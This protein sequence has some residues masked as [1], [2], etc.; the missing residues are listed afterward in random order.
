MF[1]FFALPRIVIFIATISITLCSLTQTVAAVTSFF[2]YPRNRARIS[3]TSLELLILGHIIL[4]MILHMQT[5]DEFR[6]GILISPEFITARIFLFSAIVLAVISV[7]LFTGKTRSVSVVIVASMTLP[8]IEHLTGYMFIY[9]NLAVIIIWFV[10]SI[11]SGLSY[12]KENRNSLS[13]SSAKNM[14]DSMITGVMFC[15]QDGFILLVN[16]QMQRLMTKITGKVQRNGRHFFGMLTLGETDPECS[17]AWFEDKNVIILPDETAWQFTITELLIGKKTYIQMTATEI[18]EQWTLTARLNPQ[19]ELLMRRQD[20][21]NET[22]ENLH[23]LSR[24]Q[25]TQR[26]KMRIHDVLGKHL[27]VLQST[28]FNNRTPDYSLLKTM[29]QELLDDLKTPP[30][31]PTPWDE[32]ETME[33]IF[34]AIGVGIEI[35][36]EMPKDTAKGRLFTDIT[37]EAVTNAVRHGLATRVIVHMDASDGNSHL[38]ITDNGHPPLSVKEG[39][40]I[41]GMRKMIEPFGGSLYIST[42]PKF[43]LLVVLPDFYAKEEKQ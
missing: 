3:E 8:V 43:V 6:S 9:F 23:I 18:S 26:A 38:K 11:I 16:K 20:E 36:G 5:E 40:G 13:A 35:S 7:I 22:I 34:D 32:L 1:D 12:G 19:N 39:S 24:E 2:R 27:S 10:R 4:C 31:E 30:E 42:E 33:Q 25:E 41:K 37:R 29:S 17:T 14:I 28:I 15:Q 21:L